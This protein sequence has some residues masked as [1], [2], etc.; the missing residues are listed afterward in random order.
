MSI[1]A[2]NRERLTLNQGWRFHE[3]DIA[4]PAIR[5]H[6]ASYANAKA[7]KTWGA[8]A[9]DHDD[10]GWREV[11]LPH[12][13]AVEQPCEPDENL[14][15]GFRRRGIGWYRRHFRLDA[16]DHGRHLELQFDGIATHCTVW[17]N[18]TL[19]HRN[20]CGYTSFSIDMTAL[21]RFDGD[22]N[23][24]SIRVDADSQEGWWYEGAGIY[25]HAWL[26]KR[27]PTHIIT[28]GV[29]ANPVPEGDDRWVIPADV[30][31][32]NCGKRPSDVVVELSLID[33]DGK[34]VCRGQA[35]VVVP[36]LKN[37]VG[38]MSLSV[39]APRRWFVDSPTLYTV[40]TR[41]MQA[42][43][44]IDSASTT[45]GFRTLRF[46]ANQGFFLNEKPLKLQ[47][48]CNHQD[49]AGVGVA[50]PDSLWEFRLR[51]LKEMG[52]NAYRVAHNPPSVEFLDLCDRVGILVMDE[53]R[54]FNSSP[55][56]VRQLEWLVRRDRNHPCVFLW[57]VFNE[58]PMQGSE[59]GYEMVRRMS[60]VVKAL[61]ATRPVTAAMNGGL[62]TSIN[63]SAAVD[64]VGFNY[65]IDA[66]DR[67]HEL[68]PDM[69]L[70][71]SED[72]SAFMTRGEYVTDP[73]RNV[74]DSYDTQFA[75]WGASHREAWKAVATRPY[76]A[77]GFV[78]TGFDYRGEPTP[79]QW[80]SASSFFGCMDLCGFP[81]TAFYIHQAQW[82]K[83]RPVLHLAPHWNW[84][85]REGQPV[86]VM[87]ISNADSVALWLNGKLIGEQAVDPFEMPSWQVPYAP[88]VLEA[89]AK[90]AGREVARTKSETTQ[91]PAALQLIA[92]RPGL[93][94]DGRD[95][96]P[97]TVQ[98]VD[99]AGR[100]VATANLPVTFDI[101]GGGAIIGLGNGDP[102]CHEPE[103]GNLRSLFNGLAQV[104]VQ[105]GRDA[106][107]TLTLTASALGLTPA[108]L[109]IDVLPA[110]PPASVPPARPKLVLQ[111]WRMS[112]VTMERPDPN[113]AVAENDMN[114]WVT[115][116]PGELQKFVAGRWANY[117][118]T[119]LPFEAMRRHGGQINFAGITGRS[120]IWLDGVRLG[121]T[122]APASQ[123]EVALPAAD[124]PRMLNVLI[125]CN[126]GELAG[127]HGGVTLEESI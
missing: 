78:W 73:T 110:M 59:S 18:N 119:F 4:F 5:G 106:S 71:S 43:Q 46:D 39:V 95:A 35:A 116:E 121:A 101:S 25:R 62:F 26:V 45:C 50:L 100:F 84:A 82:V 44:L 69:A 42:G 103:K 11:E 111:G 87:A 10:T 83:D 28:D 98:A 126:P 27:S 72:T 91:S 79:L 30:T 109:A 19:V 34:T 60:A 58:E 127:L 123:I 53:N 21:A 48:V 124:S 14:S 13:W 90:K 17:L 22:L 94:G 37:A 86:H 89:V 8:A 31:L 54:H 49:H 7:G 68:N 1:A 125:E 20:W 32:Y 40:Q 104:I 56:Y 3:G 81:K 85:G 75:P 93:M 118:V 33:P 115:I 2:N 114:T 64:V 80:P 66:Y 12:D 70:T 57:S 88:G 77:G 36:V 61:D 65:Q 117:R 63:V 29:H 97:I 74:L 6:S 105:A 23:T 92:D 55:E 15:Q 113:V 9:Q 24:L 99:A 96:Q 52:V 120:E 112:P 41:L 38:K 107:G 47:G 16:A 108:K 76:L 122:P 102:N 51:K 67:F